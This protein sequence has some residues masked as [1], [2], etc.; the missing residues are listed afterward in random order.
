MVICVNRHAV[1]VWG[2][3]ISNLDAHVA[4]KILENQ[5]N[6]QLKR[7][8]SDNNPIYNSIYGAPEVI[9]EL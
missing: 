7:F 5:V 3:F 6:L 4:A 9:E 1:S 8:L 2:V